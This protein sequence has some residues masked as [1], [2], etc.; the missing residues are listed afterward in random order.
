MQIAMPIKMIN[1]LFGVR[2]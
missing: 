2:L 1:I